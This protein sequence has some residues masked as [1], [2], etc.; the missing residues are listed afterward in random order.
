M[1]E[2]LTGKGYEPEKRSGREAWEMAHNRVNSM[3]EWREKLPFG[4]AAWCR[5]SDLF[6][7]LPYESPDE[8]S[9]QAP[10]AD[11]PRAKPTANFLQ[12]VVRDFSAH[13]T[14]SDPEVVLKGETPQAQALARPVASL[15]NTF[16]RVL[17]FK[18]PYKMCIQ[19]GFKY[20][21]GIA[22]VGWQLEVDE[23][24]PESPS[25]DLDIDRY[26][27]KDSP[28]LRR[29]H[30][31]MF[32]FDPFAPD[33]D[34]Q[35]GRWAGKIVYK[36]VWQLVE[37]PRYKKSVVDRVKAGEGMRF[38]AF[39]DAS[40]SKYSSALPQ[41]MDREGL[42]ELV[43]CFEYIDKR[44]GTYFFFVMGIDEPLR[45]GSDPYPYL[46]GFPYARLQPLLSDNHY[47]QSVLG[48]GE[49]QHN[50]IQRVRTFTYNHRRKH[51]LRKLL[52][53]KKMLADGEESKITSNSDEIILT[54]LPPDVGAKELVTPD[55]PQDQW[56]VESSAKDDLK[57]IMGWSETVK[58]GT[59]QSRTSAREVAAQER[60]SLGVK[61]GDRQDAV[62]EF[63]LEIME[64][65]LTITQHEMSA[66][67]MVEVIGDGGEPLL[68]AL[69]Q[70]D[71]KL[72]FQLRVISSAE[73]KFDPQVDRAQRMQIFDQLTRIAPM[74]G[75]T[76][77]DVDLS[78]AMMFVLESFPQRG[79]VQ[80][81]FRRLT[82][83]EMQQ[84]ALAAQQ[85]QQGA[86]GVAAP[87]TDQNS[88][89]AQ[90]MGQVTG[91]G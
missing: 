16:W 72:P 36:Y 11:N 35:R 25:G 26:I 18:R 29:I 22:E 46:P 10:K 90:V 70:A 33:G 39:N 1:G 63:A 89:D 12:A 3:L 30:P 19:D 76:G 55:I 68:T 23:G 74:A 50:E 2:Q 79:E 71:T 88:P 69:Q 43:V 56:R 40:N 38:N 65:L 13:M 44:F 58:G 67:R 41:G 60:S 83:E 49:D 59:F 20:N 62:D 64:M 31:S 73:E 87:V 52:V 75:Q 14:K 27:V 28:F 53:W 84:R 48:L 32:L 34:F 91:G 7:G 24:A 17:K 86:P 77:Y 85:E 57:E 54:N 8:S 21:V 81:F 82:P 4:H 51:A 15:L 42:E 6:D 45:E 37:N 47:S 61:M 80:N 66:P 5:Y 9:A 78:A